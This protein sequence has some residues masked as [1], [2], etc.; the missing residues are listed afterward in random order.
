MVLVSRPWAQPETS[1]RLNPRLVR[2]LGVPQVERKSPSR[3]ETSLCTPG[4]YFYLFG[5]YFYLFWNVA[6]EYPCPLLYKEKTNPLYSFPAVLVL[7]LYLDSREFRGHPVKSPTNS[8]RVQVLSA[9]FTP[10]S[11]GTGLHSLSLMCKMDP[12]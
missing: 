11:L 9:S 12:E 4:L 5:L 3:E 8:T 2:D 10:R 1:G 6:W 7:M